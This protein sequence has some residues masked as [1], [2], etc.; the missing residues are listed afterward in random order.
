[1]IIYHNPR[2]SK[3]RE[4]ISILEKNKCVFEIREYLKDPPTAKEI[5]TLLNHLGCKAIDLVRKSEVLYKENY[6]GKK[7]TETQWIKILSEYPILI[8]RPIIIDGQKAVIGR[9]T[10]RVIDFVKK[11]KKKNSSLSKTD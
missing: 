2:C 5:K 3:S 11:L 6:A 1:M 8:E 7:V 4:A 10:E 9:P